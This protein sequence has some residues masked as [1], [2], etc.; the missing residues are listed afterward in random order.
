MNADMRQKIAALGRELSHDFMLATAA[1]TAPHAAK[2]DP[3]HGE[4]LFDQAYGE[5]ERH[6]IDIYGARKD[7]AKRPVVLYVHG[8]GFVAGDKGGSEKPF[9]RNVGAWASANGMLGAVLN[10]RLAPGTSWPGGR[11][12]VIAAIAWLRQ[13]APAWG[14]DATRIWIMGQ[15][16][17]AA[18]VAAVVAEFQRSGRESEL[19]GAIMASGIYDLTQVAASE[20]N[21]AYYGSDSAERA[22]RSSIKGL[23]ATSIPCLFT[24]AELDPLQF[25][26]QAALVVQARIAAKG[27]WPRM[28]L[29]PGHNHMT[30]MQTLG[31]TLEDDVSP[32]VLGFMAEAR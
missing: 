2:P 13:N 24:V 7:G 21:L 30:P 22:E 11:D 14:G 1:V 8:G 17:G 16:A 3:A 31:S 9:Y 32:L 29:L 28:H 23:A 19:A 25:Q 20:G 27:A 15:S 12:D 18:H 5:H 6:R 26:Q 10:Y 4:C